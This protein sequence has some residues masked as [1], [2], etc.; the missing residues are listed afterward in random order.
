M[1]VKKVIRLLIKPQPSLRMKALNNLQREIMQQ[2]KTNTIIYTNNKD[3]K[4][5]LNVIYPNIDV[6]TDIDL[7]LS[8]LNRKPD[9]IKRGN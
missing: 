5:C 8:M 4:E 3:I 7:A 2:R 9:D 1:R 6:I